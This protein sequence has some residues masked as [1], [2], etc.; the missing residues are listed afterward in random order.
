MKKIF[1]LLISILFISQLTA[2]NDAITTVHQS[3]NRAISQLLNYRFKGGE[4]AFEKIFYEHVDYPENG[5]RACVVGITILKFT[6][7]CD[8][9]MSELRIRNSL[10]PRINEQ[11]KEFFEA[12][13]GQWNSCE[14]EAYTNFE[15]PI[16]F[17]IRGVETDARAYLEIDA[18][19]QGSKCQSDAW[20]MEQFEKNKAKKKVKSALKALDILIQRDPYNE[21]Y[22][23]LKRALL[24]GV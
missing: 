11:L 4:G 8:N 22:Y 13:E 15:I 24:S 12:L 1:T 20:H 18:P 14:D 5:Q 23:E 7:D 16:L 17:T 9:N 19:H 10:H 21:E 3:R 2:Q 6:V